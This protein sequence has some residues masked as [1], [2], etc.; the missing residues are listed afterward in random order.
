MIDYV[1]A[2]AKILENIDVLEAEEKSIS[3]CYGQILAEDIYSDIDVPLADA[4]ALD[5]YAVR[6]EEMKNASRENPVRL[7]VVET[8]IAGHLPH[9]TVQ[10]GT[11][12]RIMTGAVM[13][14]G[15]DCMIRFEDTSASD[16][17]GNP[18]P[19]PLSEVAVF[20]PV[21]AGDNVRK[22]GENITR[23]AMVLPRGA[24]VG[25]AEIA[26]LTS[27]GKS[28]IRVTRR[29]VMAILA[30]GEE[31]ISL[32]KP[33]SPGKSY[34]S[35][36]AAITALVTHYGGI[37]KILG[38]A[39]D[40]EKSVSA[41]IQKGMTADAIV[42]SGGVSKG[43]Y[44]LIRDIITKTGRIV[45]SGVR[46]S[47]GTPFSFGMVDSSSQKSK[48]VPFFALAGNPTACMLNFELFVRP[49][50]LK[51]RG[52]Q[53]FGHNLVEAVISEPV[54]NKKE[55]QSFIWIKLEREGDEYRA[56]LAGAQKRGVLTSVTNA[57]GLAIIP[58]NTN[59]RVGETV[60]VIMLN[61]HEGSFFS[62][63]FD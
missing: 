41:K 54:S 7:H 37:P 1:E 43:D 34:D 29:P 9:K 33:L 48:R 2:T 36:T 26:V 49:A 28:R 27:I 35:N 14:S 38:V 5:G 3:K 19:E 6:S 10:P 58:E 24:T 25:P 40:S 57:D 8:V 31:I 18:R 30:S 17:A 50:I 56:K 46:I 22:A 11:A 4:S 63:P 47:P 15:A 53:E 55:L 12:I 62:T 51:M 32:D 45:F 13:P 42:S 21:K 20:A 59:F 44:D 39:R 52:L 16:E 60:K 61:W 23:G